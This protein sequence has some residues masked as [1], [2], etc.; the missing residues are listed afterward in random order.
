[1]VLQLHV[2]HYAVDTYYIHDV[3]YGA[4]LDI[5]YPLLPC[6]KSLDARWTLQC[7]TKFPLVSWVAQD[8]LF[9]RL[10]CYYCMSLFRP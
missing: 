6:G 4:S 10:L 8:W 3:F 9:D 5:E 2:C 1:M 7:L